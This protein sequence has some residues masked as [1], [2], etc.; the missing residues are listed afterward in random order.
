MR[1]VVD[2]V[3]RLKTYILGKDTDSREASEQIIAPVESDPSTATHSP[4]AQLVFND[5]LYD[6]IDSI[7]IGDSLVVGT[8]IRVADKVSVA[9]AKK[10]DQMQLST[11]PTASASNVGKVIIYIGPTTSTYTSGQSYQST[12]EG[13][14]YIWKPTSISSVDAS[15][16]AYDNQTSGLTATDAQAAIDE[17]ASQNQTLETQVSTKADQSLIAP[18]QTTLI[19]SKPYAIDEQFVY[20]GLLYT[21]TAAIAQGSTITINGNCKLSDRIAAQIK[22]SL[23]KVRDNYTLTE[24]A[25]QSSNTTF[26]IATSGYYNLVIGIGATA[27]AANTARI[28]AGSLRLMDISAELAYNGISGIFYIEAG[29]VLSFI[30]GSSTTVFLISSIT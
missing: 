9:I 12:L 27:A 4:G 3:S 8:N 29:T 23:F 2:L 5:I 10:Q 15:D 22:T 25:R 30:N 14:N 20:Q 24:V 11:M 17:L 18:I 26:T 21:A 16:V 6:V 7:A 19:A 13:G 28:K 1:T